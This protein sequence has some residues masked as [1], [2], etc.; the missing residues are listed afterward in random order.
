MEIPVLLLTM[1]FAK[2]A[3]AMPLHVNRNSPISTDEEIAS[4][5]G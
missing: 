1:H 5:R 2:L 4:Q 3:S